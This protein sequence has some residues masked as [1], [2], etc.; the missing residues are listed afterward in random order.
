MCSSSALLIDPYLLC[1]CCGWVVAFTS[2]LVVWLVYC[3]LRVAVVYLMPLLGHL[4]GL[5][6]GKLA[7]A[8]PSDIYWKGSPPRQTNTS[9]YLLL[10]FIAYTLLLLSSPSSTHHSTHHLQY[11]TSSQQTLRPSDHE[12]PRHSCPVQSTLEDYEMAKS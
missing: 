3:C 11:H 6:R 9:K 12:P 5:S 8:F 4:V 7:P 2:L 1:A 10:F